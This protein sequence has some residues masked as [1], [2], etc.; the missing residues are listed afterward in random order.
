VN[1][2]EALSRAKLRCGSDY[3]AS[4]A[5]LLDAS[6]AG[7]CS[8]VTGIR[9]EQELCF[10]CLPTLETLPCTDIATDTLPHACEQQLQR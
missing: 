4:Y 10:E 6:A 5:D 2:I 8:N 3:D 1:T 7:N 9:D